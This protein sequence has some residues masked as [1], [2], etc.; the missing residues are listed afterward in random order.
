[1]A[2][3][4]AIASMATAG[5]TLVLAGAT[6]GSVRS[7]N[8]A[9]RVAERSLLAGIRPLLIPTRPD[10]PYEKIGFQD[11]DR[12]R[13]EGGRALAMVEGDVVYLAFSLRNIGAGIAVLD[14]WC[15]A[16]G[17]IAGDQDHLPLERFHRLTRDLYLAASSQG[18]WQGALRNRSDP[19]WEAAAKAVKDR[20]PLTID[21]LYGDY[22][23]GQR[24]ITRFVIRPMGEDDWFTTASR[25][26]NLDR[27]DPR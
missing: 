8:R 12:F 3:W 5:G 17:I 19:E 26:W 2:D 27:D 20:N 4:T 23:G 14:R 24:T 1:M 11:T 10:D 13:V 9:A 25:H 22:E 6:Y 21:V 18:F 16:P 15:L 7:A